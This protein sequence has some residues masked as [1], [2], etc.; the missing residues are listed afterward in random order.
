MDKLLVAKTA[1]FC[2][3]V[4]RAVETAEGLADSGKAVRTLGQIIHNDQ[5]VAR[6]ESKGV[7]T[8]DSIDDWKESETLVI[9]SHGVP[10]STV[11]Q[12]IDH[13]GEWVDAT[14]PYVTSIHRRVSSAEKG[15]TVLIFG[16][17]D[18]P[19]VKGIAGWCSVECHILADENELE[20]HFRTHPELA[21]KPVIAV[22]QTTFNSIKWK[23]CQKSLK[24][25]CTNAK[26]FDTICKATALRQQEAVDLSRQCDLMIVIGGRHSSNTAKLRD[27][28]AAACESTY[29]IETADELPL[30]KIAHSSTVGVTAGA[31][32]PP[33]II[34]EVLIIMSEMQNPVENAVAEVSTEETVKKSFDEMTFEEALEDSLS[35][36]NTD[37]QVRG[38]VLAVDN[39][40]I[41]VDIGR[42]YA[43][44]V[45]AAEFSNDPNVDLTKE[46]KV[47]DELDLIVM[48]TND[49]EGTVSLSKRRF[50]AI[51]GWNKI[52]DASESGD[53]LDGKVVDVIRGGILVLCEGVR[54]FVP[55]SHAT[56]TRVESLD[57]MKGQD[58]RL[59][60]I[61]IGRR[62]RAVGSIR[63]VLREERKAGETKFWESAEVGKTYTGTVKTLTSYGAFVDLGGVDGMVHISE[64]SWKRIKHPSEVVN[65]GDTVEVYIKDI[66]TEKHK[67]SLGYKKDED[68]PW[69]I[70]ANNYKVGDVTKATVVNM[71]AYGAF[72]RIIDGI[73]GLVHISQIANTHIEK[74]QDVLKV[75][76]EVDVKITDIDF[77]KKRV[78]LSI[79][80]LLEDDAEVEAEPAD[81]E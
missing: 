27:I 43:G 23:K 2:F 28:C 51:A 63:N 5:A 68:N 47:G 71:T 1:G 53:I 14:C 45:T 58:V 7:R 10:K 29:L 77:D 80:A 81:A 8:I 11:Q 13:G 6:L 22:C 44:F 46:V 18:H 20:E 35:N 61:E 67:I 38:V 54:V 62:N 79:K 39:K 16:D 17:K 49:V 40:E 70:F 26:I 37:Q 55:A 36:L 50:D 59:R 33:A 21:S 30:E 25:V 12:I 76:Q 15:S 42:K 3:G 74:P 56:L 31:S 60:I 32:T 52:V 57:G 73:D 78:S 9:R 65:V 75:G 48:R 69:T 24:K 64:L 4:N 19:E 66:D 41:Q 34:K 72:A